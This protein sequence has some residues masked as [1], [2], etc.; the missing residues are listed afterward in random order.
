MHI[1]VDDVDKVY[2]QA[3]TAGGK[4]VMPVSDMFWG[5]RYGV[6][7]DPFGHK[8]SVATH[9]E[10]LSPDEIQKRGAEAMKQMA[11]GRK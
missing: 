9:K 8:W 5:D 3:I 1:Y 2:N 4:T 7:Q 10:D 11:A 6:L